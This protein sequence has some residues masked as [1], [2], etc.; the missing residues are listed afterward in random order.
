[1]KIS[2][3]FC[4]VPLFEFRKSFRGLQQKFEIR[5]RGV[6]IRQ[7]WKYISRNDYQESLSFF[8][9]SHSFYLSNATITFPI[10]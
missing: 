10:A 7:I 1:M 6:V 3:S 9:M 4:S 8:K 2:K 5:V